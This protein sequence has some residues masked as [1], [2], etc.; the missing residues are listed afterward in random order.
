MTPAGFQPLDEFDYHR[1]LAAVDGLALVLF[2][3]AACATCRQVERLLPAAA[4]AGAQLFMV[5]A[6][7]SVALTR[8][9]DL[10]HL[11]GLFLYRDGH[12]HARL[13]CQVTPAALRPAMAKA[14]AEPAQ[15]E[16]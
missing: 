13:D 1:R 5:D 4:P 11:P 12:Y 14:L 8:A 16:P 7:K 10:F 3:S 9:F 6:Q 2:S 15:E